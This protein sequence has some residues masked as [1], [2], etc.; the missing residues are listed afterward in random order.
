LYNSWR[1]DI[2]ASM[3]KLVPENHPSLHSIAEE[4]TAEEFAAGVVTKIVKELRSAIKTYA[5]DGFTAVAIAAPQIGISKRVFL[6]EDQSDDGER[7]PTVIA[8]NP[9]FTKVSKKTHVVGEGC[10]SIPDQYGLVRRA[11]NVTLE[12]Y[13]E[14]GKKFTRGAGGLLAQ[15]MQ[16]EYDH[17]DGILFTDRAEKV[18]TKEELDAKTTREAPRT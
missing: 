1:Y 12:A 11:T 16:H 9:R 14:H 3:A 8:A 6:I 17:L 7:L 4:I 10:L 13:D 2:F 5:V 18:W 15:I